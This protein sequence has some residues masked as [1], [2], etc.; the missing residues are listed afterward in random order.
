MFMYGSLDKIYFFLIKA[1]N[2]TAFYWNHI[3]VNWKALAYGA[4]HYLFIIFE[5][6]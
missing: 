3:D 2:Y 4:K 6:N 1:G 5:P